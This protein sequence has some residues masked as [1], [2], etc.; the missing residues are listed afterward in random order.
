MM[1]VLALCSLVLAGCATTTTTTTTNSNDADTYIR[2]ASPR[3]AQAFSRG[4]WNSVSGYYTDDAV[5]MAPN[6][7]TARG[8]AAIGQAFGS[9]QAMKPS[10]SLTADR[11]VQSGDLAYEYGTY[12]MQLTPPN[13]A[14]MNDRGKYLTVWRRMPNGDWKIAADIFNTS[15]PAPGM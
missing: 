3:F 10:L 9:F 5:M 11:V 1:K 7:D 15:M 4:D 12:R 2:A 8:P 14:M 13:G 6:A